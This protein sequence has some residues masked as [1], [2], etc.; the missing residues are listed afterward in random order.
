MSVEKGKHV[1]ETRTLETIEMGVWEP[2]PLAEV[3]DVFWKRRS[4]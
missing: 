4:F 2:W 1:V 3:E